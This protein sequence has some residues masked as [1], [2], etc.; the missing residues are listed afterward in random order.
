MS[1]KGSSPYSDA[2]LR[3]V[4]A[5]LDRYRDDLLR[6]PHVVGVGIGEI[7]AG[8]GKRLCIT[9]FVRTKVPSEQLAPQDRI[10]EELEGIPV[11]VEEVGEFRPL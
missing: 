6:R 11:R 5:V 4:R 7:P 10:P 8:P 1:K 9:V 3:S 2:D